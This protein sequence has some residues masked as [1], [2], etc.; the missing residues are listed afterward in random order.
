[1]IFQPSD[2][3]FQEFAPGRSRISFG[4]QFHLV[5]DLVFSMLTVDSLAVSIALSSQFFVETMR[6]KESNTHTHLNEWGAEGT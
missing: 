6:A 2:C 1:M 5:F 4:S 3:I